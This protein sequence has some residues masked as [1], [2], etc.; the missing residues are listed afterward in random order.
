[1]EVFELKSAFNKT[2]HV[3]TDA[4]TRKLHISKREFALA[5]GLSAEAVTRSKRRESAR[6]QQ[7]LRE[8]LEILN[9]VQEWAGG[10]NVAW[11]WYRSQPIPAFGGMTA[12]ELVAQ[13]RANEVR[14][15]LSQIA[16]GG[17]A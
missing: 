16:T 5:I 10:I 15:Y 7:R 6:T 11:S 8:T 13:N 3:D 4:L 1:M 12:E 17:Y 2:G 9:R 14:A